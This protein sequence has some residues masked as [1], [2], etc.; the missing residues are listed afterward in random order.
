MTKA[1]IG[2]GMGV[3]IGGATEQDML[4]T[5]SNMTADVQ[6]IG[7]AEYQQRIERAQALMRETG[8]A[9]V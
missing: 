3:G 6:P 1:N 4:A 9:A 2:V 7:M 8:L 5:L